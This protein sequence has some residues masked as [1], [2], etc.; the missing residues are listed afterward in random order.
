MLAVV[1]RGPALIFL[2]VA[3]MIS[4]TVW[5]DEAEDRDFFV[6]SAMVF[7]LYHEVGHALIDRLGIPI[8]GR[9]EDAADN[10][11]TLLISE[12]R[13][14]EEREAMIF[15]AADSFGVADEYAAETGEEMLFWGEH[16][17][18]LQR[19]F[20]IACVYYGSNPEN[21]EEFADEADLPDERRDLCIEEHHDLKRSWWTYLNPMEREQG[22]DYQGTLRIDWGEAEGEDSLAGRAALQRSGLLATATKTFNER[23]RLPGDLTVFLIECEEPGAFYESETSAITLCYELAADFAGLFDWAVQD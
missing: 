16:S 14:R 2:L 23:F 20:G 10:L 7:T 15:A 13:D 11:A 12:W 21:L 6:D 22:T 17:V 1:T 19:F 9:E 4:T 3:V 8:L 5:A 18:D